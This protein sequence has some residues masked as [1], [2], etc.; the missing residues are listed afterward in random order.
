VL[1]DGDLEDTIAMS[2]EWK[3]YLTEYGEES[4]VPLEPPVCLKTGMPEN[5]N[6]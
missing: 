1:R 5:R 3:P 6:A 2:D 4:K